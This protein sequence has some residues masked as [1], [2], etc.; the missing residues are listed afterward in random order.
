MK[1]KLI[2]VLFLLGF[3]SVSVHA[4]LSFP[5]NP[6]YHTEESKNQV[7][8]ITLPVFD[9]ADFIERIKRADPYFKS[10]PYSRDIPVSYNPAN[11]GKWTWDPKGLYIWRIGFYSYEARSMS[12]TFKNFSIPEEAKVFAYSPD[13][14]KWRGAFTQASSGKN[15]SLRISPIQNDTIIIELQVPWEYYEM[16]EL[17]IGLVSHGFKNSAPPKI[18]SDSI[19]MISGFCNV[20]INCPEGSDWQIEK[21]SVCRILVQKYNVISPGDTSRW[22]EVCTGILVNNTKGD[23]RPFLLTAN[24]CI[25][26]EYEAGNAVFYFGYESPWC[27]GPDGSNKNSLF[28]SNLLA[29]SDRIDFTLI[30]LD[31]NPPSSYNPYYSGWSRSE[32]PPYKTVCIHHPMGD[33]MKIALDNDPPLVSSYGGLDTDAFWWIQKWETATTESGSSGSPLFDPNHLVIGILSGG[34]ATCANPINDFFYRIADAWD[35]YP[36]SL[37]QLKHWLDPGGIGL[38]NLPGKDPAKFQ[39]TPINIYPNPNN[40][41]FTLELINP[42]R[43]I[44]VRIYDLSGQLVFASRKFLYEEIIYVDMSTLTAGLYILQ[45]DD[46]MT[47]VTRKLVITNE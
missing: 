17:N 16:C 30:E 10:F 8:V 42:N 11:A 18:I 25:K 28:G 47:I 34:A 33:V 21:R 5:G 41:N 36:D 39:V 7:P 19:T 9:E 4:Q 14:K 1:I 27:D 43:N 44:K 31:Q 13:G 40:G 23:E 37:N 32:E 22:S 20:D 38:V 26:N 15:G 12:V 6:M 3:G 2:S 35:N 29:T 46:G 24:H 45:V